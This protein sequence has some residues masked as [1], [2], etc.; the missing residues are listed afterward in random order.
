VTADRIARLI[1]AGFGLVYV[2]VNAGALG[3]PLDAVLRVGAVLSVAALLGVLLRGGP[4]PAGERPPVFGRGYALVVLA[5]VAAV[6]GG[7]LALGALGLPGARF[8]WLTFVVGVHFVLLARV[9]RERSIGWVGGAL[10]VCGALGL[11]AALAGAPPA[12]VTVLAGV[13]PGVLLL[14]GSWWGV[15]PGRSVATTP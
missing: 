15:G 5:E 14:A 13:L 11:G 3:S 7:S 10:A 8:P 4:G 2:L 12:A 6:V 1:G 9:W